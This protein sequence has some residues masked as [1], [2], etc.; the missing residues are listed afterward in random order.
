VAWR[1]ELE[2]LHVGAVA[3]HP[4]GEHV[5]RPEEAHDERARRLLEDL[6]G[7]AHLLDAPGVHEHHAVGDLEG[8]LL[9]VGHEDA[10]H[11]Q[12]VV[13]P[14]Q[15]AAELL[16]D[17][18]V[19]RAE[20]LVEEEEAGLGGEGA[21][22]R[23]ALALAAG[24][25]VGVALAEAVELDER[26]E[27]GH[28]RR[29]LGP[30]AAADA[31]GEADVL[32]HR[33][34]AEEGVVLEHHAHVPL[35]GGDRRDV[36]AAVPHLAGVGRLEPGDDAEEGGLPA[37]GRAEEGD[38]LTLRDLERDVPEDGVPVEGLREA[39]DLDAHGALASSG[40]AARRA[41][42]CFHSR[43]FFATSVTRASTKRSEATAKAARNWYS[44]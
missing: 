26:E 21:R 6:R 33:H 39:L 2:V 22:E 20:G 34:V 27:L 41:G 3:V 30:R 36:L 1:R 12:L 24:E 16:A 32:G 8:L 23:H 15:P 25:L 4:A 29:D 42:C 5:H 40:A 43:A 38:E 17:A 28:P 44:L 7:G 13:E 11:V 31:Q 18:G 37:A 9:V 19:E 14:A 10:R 35:A